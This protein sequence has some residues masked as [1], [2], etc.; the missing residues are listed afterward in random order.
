[1]TPTP[2]SRLGW[3]DVYD[4]VAAAETRIVGTVESH[5]VKSAVEHRDMREDIRKLQDA[6]L[7]AAAKKQGEARI[8]GIGKMT[9]AVVIS[10]A[11]VLIQAAVAVLKFQ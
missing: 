7:A 10:V 3:R 1:M 9:I 5:A 2:S 8:L 6:Q 11:G 4:L